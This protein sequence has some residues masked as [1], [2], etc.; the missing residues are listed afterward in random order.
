MLFSNE[1]RKKLEQ[2]CTISASRSSGPGGQNVNKVNTRVELRFSLNQSNILSEEEKE[3]TLNKLKNRIN[4][5]GELVLFSESERT[6]SGNKLKVLEK[7]IKLLE[8]ALTPRK[9][10]IKTSPSISSGLKRLQ[11]KKLNAQKKLLR[12]PPEVK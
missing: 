2:E 3:R 12:K 5:A 6:Q 7:F 9:K 11:S 10:R 1:I 4:S 8:N